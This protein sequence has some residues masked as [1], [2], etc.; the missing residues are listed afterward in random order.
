M[1]RI[2]LNQPNPRPNNAYAPKIIAF[3]NPVANEKWHK[4]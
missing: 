2:Q 3:C 1:L 4:N